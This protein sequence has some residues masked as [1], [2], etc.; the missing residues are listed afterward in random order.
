[1]PRRR[2]I[3]LFVVVALVLAACGGSDSSET[4]KPAQST[5]TAVGGHVA[6]AAT[7]EP[8]ISA[9]MVCETDAVT[10][11]ATVIGV[12]ARISTPT[13]KDSI[14]SCDYVYAKGAK[15]TLSVKEVSSD[16]ETTAYYDELARQ[17]GKQQDLASR[18]ITLGQG[19]FT[20]DNGSVVTRKDYK[21]LLV[22]VS[23]L[24]AKFG[25]PLDTRENDAINVAVTLME[26]WVGA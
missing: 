18:G 24:P 8:S 1:V 25:V 22:D 16:A 4:S 14:Y 7:A 13:W 17:L 26:C 5:T 2:L 15:M 19:A 11:I 10:S 3:L 12:D 6:K 23:E 9:K 21:V 20:T